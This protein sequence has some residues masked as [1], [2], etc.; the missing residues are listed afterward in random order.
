MKKLMLAL[1][2]PALALAFSA[3]A[4]KVDAT[5]ITC[6]EFAAQTP[7]DQEKITAF[8]HG[9]SKKGVAEDAL[10]EVEVDRVLDVAAIG[11]VEQPKATLWDKFLAK[12]PGGKKL[13]K[14]VKMTCEE[15]MALGTD[16]QPEV[17]YFLD[18]YSRKDKTNVA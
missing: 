15:F 2:V 9:Y 14:P 11:C 13:I 17:A 18:G 1:L 7:E 12:I 8:L 5:K 4:K 6:E 16:V 10:G 3:E